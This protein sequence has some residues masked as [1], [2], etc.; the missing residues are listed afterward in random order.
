MLKIYIPKSIPP[1]CSPFSM[2]P[3]GFMLTRVNRAARLAFRPRHGLIFY[4]IVNASAAAGLLGN[5]WDMYAIFETA[6]FIL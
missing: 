3:I 2:L 6:F 1:I 5:C 4:A